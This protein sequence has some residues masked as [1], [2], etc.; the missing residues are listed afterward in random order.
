VASPA[1]MS[2]LQVSDPRIVA[3]ATLP[4]FGGRIVGRSVSETGRVQWQI[5]GLPRDFHL[6]V[7]DDPALGEI[8]AYIGALE[9]VY[10]TID[11]RARR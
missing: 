5:A 9:V 3:L 4:R 1:D 8:R 6:R 11:R 2:V 10:G 7:V